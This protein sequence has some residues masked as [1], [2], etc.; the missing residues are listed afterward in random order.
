MQ[1]SDEPTGE[2]ITNVEHLDHADVVNNSAKTDVA[3]SVSHADNVGV[4][5]IHGIPPPSPRAQRR[6]YISDI[7]RWIV[8]L[9]AIV[10][11]FATIIDKNINENRL[12]NQIANLQR[13]RTAADAIASDKLECVRRYQ[14]VIDQ[15]S[16]KQ[17]ILLGDFLVDITQNAPGPDREAAV[18]EGIHQLDLVNI[19]ARAAL[20]AKI[21]YINADTPLPCPLS[22]TTPVA[23]PSAPTTIPTPTPE[24]TTVIT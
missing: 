5:Q 11:M 17:L 7:T 16:E 2:S 4:V 12:G 19:N 21:D 15:D 24:S 6:A 1:T 18:K 20:K 13:Q 10:V 3:A 8:V 22:P 14:D 23:L 9:S